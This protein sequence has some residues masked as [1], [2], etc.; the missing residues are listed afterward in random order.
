MADCDFICILEC[1]HEVFSS[2]VEVLGVDLPLLVAKTSE[3]PAVFVL[4]YNQS[5]VLEFQSF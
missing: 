3:F 2:P 5:T 4:Y 1:V